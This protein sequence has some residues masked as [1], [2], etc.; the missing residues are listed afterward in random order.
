MQLFDIGLTQKLF[1]VFKLFLIPVGG[2]IPSGVLLARDSGIAWPVTAALYLV[3]DLVLALAFE[4]ILRILAAIA[5]RIPFLTRVHAALK[6]ANARSV[7]RLTGTSTGPL[8]LIT[9]AF[10]VDPMT[11]R[12]TALAAG[13]GFL[14]GWAFAIA[15]DLLYFAVIA[16]ST[17]QLSRYI[18]DPEN[19][20]LIILA[21]MILVPMLLRRLR[22]TAASV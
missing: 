22:S 5:A 11:G 17:L 8:A 9:I 21:L 18:H 20:A 13:H 6:A 12:A 4:P 1:P 2:G 10:G 3:S 15:G 19:T 16:L 7:T 14:A